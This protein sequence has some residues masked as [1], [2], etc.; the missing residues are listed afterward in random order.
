[1]KKKKVKLTFRGH[2]EVCHV[3]VSRSQSAGKSGYFGFKGDTLYCWGN[4]VA[5]FYGEKTVLLSR[6]NIVDCRMEKKIRKAIPKGYKIFEVVSIEPLYHL[7]NIRHTMAAIKN[8]Y[9]DFW[10]AR[11]NKKNCIWRNAEHANELRRYTKHFGLKMPSLKG[12]S[13]QTKKAELHLNQYDVKCADKIWDTAHAANAERDLVLAGSISLEKNWVDGKAEE[14]A[15]PV[16]R[17]REY[18]GIYRTVEFSQ[19]RVRVDPENKKE[20]ETSGGAYVPLKEA[21]LLYKRIEAGKPVHGCKIGHY[22][23]TGLNGTLRVGCHEITRQEIDR[24]AKLMKW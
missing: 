14:A 9:D 23:A 10:K 22:T 19:I 17:F 12:I 8:C 5:R 20:L 1:M 21:R 11:E 13:L 7:K 16:C 18:H 2:Q 15:P 3:W 4:P 6:W 24:F